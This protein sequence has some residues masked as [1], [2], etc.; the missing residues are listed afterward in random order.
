LRIVV[1]HSPKPVRVTVQTRGLGFQIVPSSESRSL[2]YGES[3]WPYRLL[4]AADTQAAVQ[5]GHFEWELSAGAAAALM[6]TLGG[7]ESEAE[8]SL[9]DLRSSSDLLDAATHRLW[10]E[11]LAS[12]PLVAPAEPVR[13]TI[14][15]LNKEETIAPQELVRSELWFWRGLLNTTC[16]VRYLPACPMMIADW[17]D[18]MGMWSNEI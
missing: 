1:V 16:Q 4:L 12:V 10:N 6:I 17:N 2:S 5:N 15:A 14:N 3:K 8:M 13:F 11:Y 7:T 9:A 18:F